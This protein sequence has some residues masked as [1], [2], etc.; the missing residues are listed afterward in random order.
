MLIKLDAYVF[1]VTG[2][3]KQFKNK[4]ALKAQLKRGG[5]KVTASMAQ[6]TTA[7][8]LGEGYTPMRD[9]AIAR[10]LLILDEAQAQQLIQAGE[11]EIAD[12]APP[13]ETP[14]DAQIGE[15]RSAL[16]QPPSSS[17]WD[18]IIEA[19]DH[20]PEPQLEELVTYIEGHLSRWQLEPQAQWRPTDEASKSMHRWKAAQP[21]G[22]LRCAPL[23]WITAMLQGQESA[24]YKLV[25]AITLEDLG[26]KNADVIKLLKLNTLDQLRSLD[27]GMGNKYSPNLWKTLRAAPSTRKLE[28][29]KIAELKS[30]HVKELDGAHHLSALRHV[31]IYYYFSKFDKS[32]LEALTKVSWFEQVET[33]TLRD[34]GNEQD[35]FEA[36]LNELPAQQRFNIDAE[37]WIT[38]LWQIM[39][40][41]LPFEEIGWI[42][43][44]YM[45]NEE[46]FIKLC[47]IAPSAAKR[48]DLSMIS[49]NKEQ[50]DPTLGASLSAC[51]A[52]W[53]ERHFVGSAMATTISQVKLGRW[54]T[55]ALSDK[56]AAHNTIAT[57]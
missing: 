2:N 56:L 43:D 36:L 30:A 40:W 27:L 46:D 29:L 10:G 19:V 51:F 33:L 4:D 16:A 28:H 17:L 23:H 42:T 5:A 11:L 41:S 45:P 9:T 24:K 47:A 57:R 53:L 18:T 34:A 25:R 15:L 55:Q 49:I 22:E 14:R 54:W 26:V 52:D 12:P 48:L 37:L 32:A 50:I 44:L 31:T 38:P 3:F 7:V 39:S 6:S 13:Q 21:R 35:T 20:C 1:C 8:I